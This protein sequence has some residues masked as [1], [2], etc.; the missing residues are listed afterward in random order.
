MLRITLAVLLLS[1]LLAACNEE[2]QT[3]DEDKICNEDA[4]CVSGMVCDNGVCRNESTADCDENDVDCDGSWARV[5]QNG[6]WIRTTD[7]ANL[8]KIC[9]DGE[10]RSEAAD[11]TD[12]DVECD[13][14]W[15]RLCQDGTWVRNMDCSNLDKICRDGECRTQENDED[16]DIEDEE[17]PQSDGDDVEDLC[18][19]GPDNSDCCDGCHVL[20]GSCTPED[21]N[22]VAGTCDG[23]ICL[24]DGCLNGYDVSLDRLS[25][26]E[27]TQP[28]GDEPDGDEP[29]GDEPDGD[30][31]DGD[32]PDG[33]EPD[34]DGPDGDEPDGDE[35]DG[36]E[37]DGDGPDGD[38]SDGD[39]DEELVFCTTEPC[40][41][42]GLWLTENSPCSTGN[43]IPA[44]TN[45]QCSASHECLPTVIGNYCLLDGQCYQGGQINPE[46]PCQMCDTTLNAWMA[47]NEG[48]VCNDDGNACNGVSTC[49]QGICVARTPAVTCQASDECHLVGNCDPQT[50]LCSQP[51]QV[52]GTLCGT[53]DQC[54]QG[55]CVDCLNNAGCQD[56]ADDGLEC[57]AKACDT[58]THLCY[59]DLDAYVGQP[60]GSSTDSEC[61][62]PD[63]CNA[64]GICQTNYEA[65][66]TLCNDDGDA[67]NGVSTCQQGRCL[68]STPVVVCQAS[69]ECH[70]VGTCDPSSGLCSNPMK[71]NGSSC[72]T[73]DQCYQGQCVDCLSD[74]ACSD[75][76]DDGLEC[77][78]VVCNLDTH[79]CEHNPSARVGEICGD[80][81]SNECYQASTCNT[82][83]TC[84]V[85]AKPTGTL[86]NDDGNLCNGVSACNEG[87][88]SQSTAPVVCP[89]PGECQLA[90]ICNPTTGSCSYSNK[91][92][93]TSCSSGEGFCYHG[94]CVECVMDSQCAGLPDDGLECTVPVCDP[95]THICVQDPSPH[96]GDL[97]GDGTENDCNK[98]DTCDAN[99]ICQ[100]NYEPAATSCDGGNNSV[101]ISGGACDGLGSCQ[102]G[103]VCSGHGTCGSTGCSCSAGYKGD[104]CEF[105]TKSFGASGY[106]SV[107]DTALDSQGNIYLTGYFSNTVSFGS[108][109]PD[110]QWRV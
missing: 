73:S 24:I 69:N 106:D 65:S 101:C 30:E 38:D 92:D 50:G 27:A 109:S 43:S 84:Q 15:V 100:P 64:Q 6:G 83:G 97:C 33:D 75:L 57:S 25:C 4:D 31:P 9:Q 13:G 26:T 32:E 17:P 89:A 72:G 91:A 70:Q 93:G 3:I 99:G 77:T 61:D 78:E 95:E 23:E 98:P 88:C 96:A 22:A 8:D 94:Q 66:S 90:G 42:G 79:L 59:H 29:D 47:Y 34:G 53:S 45:E 110:Q 49:Q 21:A 55:V 11:C 60:C 76:A 67:C 56:L 39:A 54:Y 102:D 18:D 81:P 80:A 10:C 48:Q 1:L 105:W 2:S 19:C 74:A 7:C 52:D 85:N 62:N 16:G 87:V 51:L 82:L 35:P 104:F 37:P 44:C 86:C 41:Q 103:I 12:N 58:L 107:K 68:V 36:D 20:E 40:C 14:N 46:N 28:D 63:T 108:T 5:C 71:E